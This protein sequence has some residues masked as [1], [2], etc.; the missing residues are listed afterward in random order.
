ALLVAAA[1]ASM[2]CAAASA[3]PPGRLYAAIGLTALA[4]GLRN[5]TVRRLAVADLTTTVLTSVLTALAA[6]SGFAGG[7]NPRLGRRVASVLSMFAG[8]AV[9]VLLLRQGI[10][11]PLVASGAGVLAATAYA[12]RSI[13]AMGTISGDTAPRLVPARKEGGE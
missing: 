13:P 7:E 12:V 1:F 3:S 4:M 6:D 2:G 10:A 9:G 8:P 5:A 11:L